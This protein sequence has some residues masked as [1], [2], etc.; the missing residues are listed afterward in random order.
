MGHVPITLH[1]SIKRLQSKSSKMAS[2]PVRRS[3]RIVKPTALFESSWSRKNLKNVTLRKLVF[4]PE[5]SK[6]EALNG[7]KKELFGRKL[8]LESL[9]RVL[10]KFQQFGTP[11]EKYSMTQLNQKILEINEL[12][13]EISEALSGWE[14]KH[15]LEMSR[16][17]VN[18]AMTTNEAF[19][20]DDVF[21]NGNGVCIS[22]K[23]LPAMY[24]GDELYTV[25]VANGRKRVKQGPFGKGSVVERV[26]RFH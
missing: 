14:N 9:L 3:P 2:L 26:K 17:D 11:N 10:Y 20:E 15:F 1:L 19:G 5:V 6:V 18:L 8:R 24:N 22:F 16:A 7:S 25:I 4:K 13:E 12:L 21:V 23:K